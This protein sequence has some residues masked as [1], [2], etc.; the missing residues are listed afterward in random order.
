MVNPIKE[1][2]VQLR[3]LIDHKTKKLVQQGGIQNSKFKI[4][5][6]K[7]RQSNNFGGGLGDATV[8]QSGVW[9]RIPQFFWLF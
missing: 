2:T 9:G 7:L 3:K 4:Q 8:T 6:S 5:N 1:N